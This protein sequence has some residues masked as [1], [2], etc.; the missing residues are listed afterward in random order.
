MRV[1]DIFRTK[2]AFPAWAGPAERLRYLLRYATLA[3]SRHNAQPWLFEIDGPELRVYVDPRRA[4]KSAD[5]LG[6]EATMACGAAVENLC[7]AAAWF[8]HQADVKT[9]DPGHEQP[10]AVVRLAGRRHPTPA[11]AEL[12]GAIP[13]RR[14]ALALREDPVEPEDLAA[15]MGEVGVDAALRRNPAL[16]GAASDRARGRGRRRPVGERALPRRAG[17]LDA[18]PPAAPRGA[19]P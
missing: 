3:P 2:P 18:P 7:L 11:E 17:P 10:I 5:P 9:R 16:A 12:F 4:L 14:T 13:R 1:N 8:G 15:L 19:G 6:R